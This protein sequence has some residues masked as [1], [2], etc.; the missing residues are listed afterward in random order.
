M[1]TCAMITALLRLQLCDE[2][3]RLGWKPNEGRL[4][5][6][7]LF[8]DFRYRER[9]KT[10]NFW[11]T[12][13]T[14]VAL[15]HH[16]FTNFFERFCLS[17]PFET[18]RTVQKEHACQGALDWHALYDHGLKYDHKFSGFRS[19]FGRQGKEV[20]YRA[21]LDNLRN[22]CVS[23]FLASVHKKCV[24]QKIAFS[25]TAFAEC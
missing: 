2:K 14:F 6:R 19:G 21:R 11:S 25:F 18:H 24:K 9:M 12:S 3:T 13:I 4:I 10:R 5:T 16:W 23:A 8:F 22:V 1:K 17:L 7:W 15:C 20:T